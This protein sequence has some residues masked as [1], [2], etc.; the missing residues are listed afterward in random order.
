M[1]LSDGVTAVRDSLDDPKK[2]KYTDQEIVRMLDQQQ[3]ALFETLIYNNKEHSN[4]TLVLQ[5][6]SGRQLFGQRRIVVEEVLGDTAGADVGRVNPGQAGNGA[7]DR[8]LGRHAA[9]ERGMWRRRI[10]S[11]ATRSGRITLR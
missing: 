2:A 4:M 6:E 7:S 5:A 11:S 8:H 3:R 10:S 9:G 1:I